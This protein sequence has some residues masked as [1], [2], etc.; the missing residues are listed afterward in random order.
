QASIGVAFYPSQGINADELI[1]NADIAMYRAKQ[2]GGGKVMHYE[3]KMHQP[4]ESHLQTEHLL[5]QAIEQGE[6]KVH[7]QPLYD[8]RSK[9]I[10]S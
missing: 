7:Y 6:I 8:N 3:E 9:Q 2:M 10:C 5:S 1:K 4:F